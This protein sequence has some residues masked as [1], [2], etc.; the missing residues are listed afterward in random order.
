[1]NDLWVDTYSP[2]NINDIYGNKNDDGRSR[3]TYD[4]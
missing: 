1:M 3:I 4:S 2:S